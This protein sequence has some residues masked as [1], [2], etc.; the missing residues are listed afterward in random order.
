MDAHETCEGSAISKPRNSARGVV[1]IPGGFSL[2][3]SP[4]TPLRRFSTVLATIG[5][6]SKELQ[7]DSNSQKPLTNAPVLRQQ[8]IR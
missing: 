3:S 2:L 8:L 5:P 6:N 1:V 4:S 7:S